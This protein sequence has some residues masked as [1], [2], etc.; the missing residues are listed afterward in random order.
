MTFPKQRFFSV[1]APTCKDHLF[2]RHLFHGNAIS[3][4]SPQK[5]FTCSKSKSNRNTRKMCEI[6][7]FCCHFPDHL[8]TNA[9]DFKVQAR[10]YLERSKLF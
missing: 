9:S 2:P 1:T 7:Y 4:M 8:G 5:T 6:C 3:G 10:K